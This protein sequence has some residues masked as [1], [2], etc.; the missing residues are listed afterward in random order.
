MIETRAYDDL[1]R[2][3]SLENKQGETILSSYSYELNDAG[4]R[5]SV[6]EYD[7][8]TVSYTY[9]E[10]Y[11][12][13]EENI[14]GGERILAYTYDSVGNRLTK[15]DSLA[16]LTTYT[17]DANDRLLS[18]VLTLDGVT[19][20]TITYTYDDNG[21][22]LSRTQVTDATSETT[23]YTWND[24]DRL[25]AVATPDGSSVTYE[26]DEQ[27]I[28]V[29]STV[30]GV[31]TD[32]LVDKNR[33][34]AQ[35][36]EEFNSEQLQAFYVYGHDLISQTRNAE[37]DFYQVDGLGST[38]ALTDENGNVTDTYDYEAFGELI[39]SEGESEN[40][41][42]FAGEQFDETLGDYYLR[43]R[44]YDPS[45]GRFTRRDTW[46]GD[47][48]NPIS[49]HKY[50][51]VHADP[52]NGVDPTGLYTLKK[53]VLTQILRGALAGSGYGAVYGGVTGGIL[54]GWRGAVEGVIGG[55]A[56]GALFGAL[57]GGAVAAS[58]ILGSTLPLWTLT[59]FSVGTGIYTSTKQLQSSDSKVKLIG[60]INL[61]LS[62]AAGAFAYQGFSGRSLGP[63]FRNDTYTRSGSVISRNA[64]IPDGEY[65]YAVGRDGKIVY[66]LENRL[67]GPVSNHGDLLGGRNVLTAGKI[68]IYGGKV[69]RIDNESGHYTPSKESVYIAELILKGKG[70]WSQSSKNKGKNY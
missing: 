16:G 62:I 27:G 51:Y 5:L 46:Q 31:T 47:L 44:F 38:R 26:Y 4:H 35:V 28:R 6:T 42:R 65:L 67:T 52:V 69:R 36:L 1:N 61:V 13:T 68:R 25:V 53:L 56:A 14:N 40:S 50:L 41:Y 23:T 32:Y 2:L 49:L 8:R 59:T 30:D 33:P 66:G 39:E 15:D 48:A 43:Q 10:L 17:Y 21:N 64:T 63:Q 18:E 11:R 37:Q 45:S 55:A 3:T 60:G 22:L 54:G 9:D 24:D 19:I 29:S 7:G 57:G 34:Y 12:L 20:H 70:F 58:A